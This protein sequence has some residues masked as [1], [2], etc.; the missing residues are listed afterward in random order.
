M[1]AEK[2][3]TIDLAERARRILSDAGLVVEDIDL[4]GEL[5]YCGTTKR[6]NG[7][8]GRYKVHM[9]FPP[10]VWFRNYHEGGESQTVALYDKSSQEDMT[11]AEREAIRERLRQE[12]EEERHKREVMQKNASTLANQI[13]YKLPQAGA[14][15]PYLKKKG[16]I[17]MGDMRECD[18][19]D[20]A[21]SVP[22]PL[23]GKILVIPVWDSTGQIVSLQYIDGEGNKRFLKGGKKQGCFFLIPSKNGR[24]TGPVL[25]GE[26]VATMA[27]ACLATGYA[28]LVAF[29]AGNLEAVGHVALWKYFGEELIFL[30]D[31]DVHDDGTP[32]TGVEASQ[33]AAQAVNGKL[34][35][36]PTIRGHKADFNDLFTDSDDGPERVRTVIEQARTSEK[37]VSL[38]A[39][40]WYD[41]K[42]GS[43]MYDKKN[44]KGDVVGSYKI[45][46]H[47]K[48]I[49]RTYGSAKWGILLEWKDRVNE[50]KR[51]SIPSRLFQQQGSTWAEMLADD[52]LDIEVGQQ[53]AFKQFILAQKEGRLIYNVNKIGWFENSFVLPDKTIGPR[54]GEVV[55]QTEAGGI[56]ELYQTCGDLEEWRKLAAL[57][58]GNTRFEFALAVGFAA[59]LLKFAS[60]DGTIFNLEGDSTTGKSTALSLVASIWGNPTNQVRA[61]RTTDNGLESVCPLHNDNILILDELGQISGKALSEV[62]YMF[63]NG[64]GKTRASRNGSSRTPMRWRGILLSSGELGLTVKLNEDGIQ[65]RAGQEVR[66]IG[67]PM[68]K[69][70]VQELHGL[71]S[72]EFFNK[73]REV[74]QQNYGLAGRIFLRNLIPHLEKLSKDFSSMLDE[75]E[76]QLC[77]IGADNQVRRVARRFALVYWGGDIAQ[78][79]KVLPKSLNM[80]DAVNSCFQDWLEA[81]GGTGSSEDQDILS[82]VRHFIC[83]HGASRFQDIERPDSI[84]NNRVGFR[85]ETQ[86]GVTEFFVLPDA[87]RQDVLRGYDPKRA[88]QALRKAGW[89]RMQGGKAQVVKRLP[90]LGTKRVYVI[91]LPADADS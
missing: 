29:D 13:F 72:V 45:C 27:S 33:K 11:E 36:C 75:I 38:P 70:D 57:C 19:S 20:A 34:A 80:I 41:K 37:P 84:C 55:L 31:N 91:V 64:I 79:L 78:Q 71:D 8:D 52:G 2:Y 35:I 28:G 74:P 24:D 22:Q 77:P 56:R 1:S 82:Q 15:N 43:L 60:M 40:Y 59:P 49:G 73:L 16:C 47:V 61:W 26:G 48:V 18:A 44:A 90:N 85:S 63:S 9:D 25:I 89:L 68:R 69:T 83:T 42:D 4:S 14:E 88:V 3:S 62:T 65:A 67:I 32:N 7:T 50:V 46:S 58:A 10:N 6:P 39:G 23:S 54:E 30:A 5:V 81:R 86:D 51:L 17:P 12:K 21:Y 87:F 53:T 76:N 66:F